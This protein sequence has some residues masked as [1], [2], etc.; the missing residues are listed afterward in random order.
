M[1]DLSRLIGEIIEHRMDA[2]A[3]ANDSGLGSVIK[4][5]IRSKAAGAAARV[6]IDAA[7]YVTKPIRQA[8]ADKGIKMAD[9]MMGRVDESGMADDSYAGTKFLMCQNGKQADQYRVYSLGYELRYQIKKS[10][11]SKV[12]SIKD[13]DGKK[14]ATIK[15]K[16]FAFRFPWTMQFEPI[17]FSIQ[18]EG[19][20]TGKIKTHYKG[21]KRIVQ[22]SFNDWTICGNFW[23]TKYQIVSDDALIASISETTERTEKHY[24]VSCVDPNDL[25]MVLV[26]MIVSQNTD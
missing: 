16:R 26:L 2:A 8:A 6:S 11:I 1:G 7:D 12:I 22:S 20:G 18:I 25:I 17:D 9:A 23:G 19:S 4:R 5:K 10:S 3:S 24:V 14:Q 15:R 13:A 21:T